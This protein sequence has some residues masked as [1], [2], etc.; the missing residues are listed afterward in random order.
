M[1]TQLPVEKENTVALKFVGEV[2]SQDY[3]Q[4]LPIVEKK[5]KDFEKINLYWELENFKGWDWQSL[6]QE[7]QFDLSYISSFKRVAI[8]GDKNLEQT[9]VGFIK[10]FVPF[11]LKFFESELKEKALTWV[12]EG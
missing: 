1:F 6:W 12:N 7:I 3:H 11:K 4:L 10:P 9:V 8:V 2:T 5:I